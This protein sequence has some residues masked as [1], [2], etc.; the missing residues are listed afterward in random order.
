MVKE[1]KLGEQN[2]TYTLKISPRAKRLR[3]AI[4]CNGD[5]IVTQPRNLRTEQVDNFI[6]SKSAWII[7]RI[8]NFKNS[9]VNPLNLLTRRDYLNA[10]E[11]ARKLVIER[12]E[13]FNSFYNFKYGTISIRDQKSRW[14][15]CSRQGNL[16]F[17]FRLLFL[18]P[19]VSDYVIVHELCH[20]KEFNH[21]ASFWKLVTHTIPDFR[22]LRLKLKNGQLI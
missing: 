15:S 3:L 11:K 4:Y 10:R 19:E 1:I 5:L 13:Y 8:N 14:G 22:A 12:L 6:L 21:S 7:S 9:P 18:P 17:N 16:N 2:I 20:L